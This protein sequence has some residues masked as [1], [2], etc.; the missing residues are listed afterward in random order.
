MHDTNNENVERIGKYCRVNN[1]LYLCQKWWIDE[2]KKFR[3]D[4]NWENISELNISTSKRLI[5]IFLNHQFAPWLTIYIVRNIFD[6]LRGVPPRA[7]SCSCYPASF[8][9]AFLPQWKAS[10][11]GSLH[12][13]Y[14][15]TDQK[16]FTIGRTNVLIF[17]FKL[18]RTTRETLL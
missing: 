4:N 15:K 16:V 1:I 7:A 8:S 5:D 12:G 2:N 3:F 11:A 17:L 9:C 18:P 14:F 6:R 13:W 10:C